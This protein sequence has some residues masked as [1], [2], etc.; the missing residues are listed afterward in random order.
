MG[1]HQATAYRGWQTRQVKLFLAPGQGSQ[2]PGFL[3][4]WIEDADVRELVGT[5]GE[6]AK[7][8]LLT[9]GTTSDAD[10]IR[11]TSIAQPLIVAASIV[12]AHAISR[13]TT[14]R[15][16]GV[17]GHSVGE[18]AAA[19][20]AG[21]LSATD[22]LA[23]VGVRARAMAD[24]A[25]EQATGMSAVVGGEMD[26]VLAA[27]EA[28]GAFPANFNG[29]GQIVAA[30]S[31]EAL[32]QLAAAP[33]AGSRVIP[34]AVAGAF[35]T[36]YMQSAQQHVAD[37]A[38]QLNPSN[39]EIKLW[40]NRDGS[41]VTDGTEFVNTLVAQVTSPVRWDLCQASF[42]EAGATGLIELLPGGALAGLAKRALPGVPVV[43]VK[44]PDDVQ[45]AV[46]LIESKA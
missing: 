40:T 22:A 18:F 1:V 19:A 43:A 44:T 30:G 4:P 10:T 3:S 11:D 31:R 2:T 29:G 37:A 42:A 36:S 5:L 39:P 13:A 45:A 15:V 21:V 16:D 8:D 41:L 33:A 17:A 34:L 12:S 32:E 27:I 14:S 26:D 25:A 38:A 7:V 20:L 35:H 9:H 28:A 46:D 24:A 6:A 23:L